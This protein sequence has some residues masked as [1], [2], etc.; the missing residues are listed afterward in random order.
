[1]KA[2]VIAALLASLTGCATAPYTSQVATVEQEGPWDPVEAKYAVRSRVNT[3][4]AARQ[5]PAQQRSF[6]TT[7]IMGYNL[8]K[9]ISN[10]NS[11][12]IKSEMRARADAMTANP[13][14]LFNPLY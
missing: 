14:E 3:L 12:M 9:N 13:S 2:I 7:G 4:P 10:M 11:A 8:F 6:L 1:M 5:Q